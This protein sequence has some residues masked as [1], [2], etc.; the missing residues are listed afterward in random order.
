MITCIDHPV[1]RV[2]QVLPLWHG[3][4]PL[5]RPRLRQGA[6]LE[7]G[8]ERTAPAATFPLGALPVG[9]PVKKSCIE[10]TTFCPAPLQTTYECWKACDFL[11]HFMRAASAPCEAGAHGWK[12]RLGD[13]DVPWEAVTTEE[14]PQK[15]IAWWSRGIRTS[16]NHGDVSFVGVGAKT[17]RVRL[18]IEFQE[19]SAA[20]VAEET[21]RSLRSA[22]DHSL[23]LLHLHLTPCG[24]LGPGPALL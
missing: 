7:V 22:L 20:A 14:T 15:R 11:P 2:F 12:L 13:G 3:V 19:S 17:T 21:V 9:G 24:V 23:D 18:A 5:R 8:P 1:S 16:R 4:R 10:L 6:V